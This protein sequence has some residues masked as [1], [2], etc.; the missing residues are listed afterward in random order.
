MLE[1]EL[2]ELQAHLA[3]LGL[4]P[5]RYFMRWLRSMFVPI[6]AIDLCSRIWDCYAR[7]GEVFLWQVA[8]ELVRRRSNFLL[9]ECSSIEV[10][11]ACL[12]APVDPMDLPQNVRLCP[13]GA[14][15]FR[16]V[17]SAPDA[18]R[19]LLQALFRSINEHE[20][21]VAKWLQ[22]LSQKLP[23]PEQCWDLY[24]NSYDLEHYLTEQ[25]RLPPRP[26]AMPSS[27]N[28][29]DPGTDGAGLPLPSPGEPASPRMGPPLGA[30]ADGREEHPHLAGAGELSRVAL[31]GS[32]SGA[33]TA[34][35]GPPSA[36]DPTID[37]T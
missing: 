27:A 9:Y 21:H 12:N 19:G 24:A 25:G 31:H 30:P 11:D 20:N 5:A 29:S 13:E 8:V 4:S 10:A 7:D 16:G 6:F 2:P 36:A 34:A 1:L 33:H 14:L 22:C 35:A 26:E 17:R 37:M 23:L 32:P 28:S 15:A 3:E 18:F